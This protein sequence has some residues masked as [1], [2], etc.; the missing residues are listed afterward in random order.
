MEK[1]NNNHFKRVDNLVKQP[2]NEEIS[3]LFDYLKTKK[4]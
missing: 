4:P 2:T 3:V 1:T